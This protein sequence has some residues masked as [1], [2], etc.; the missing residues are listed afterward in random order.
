MTSP[1]I[2]ELVHEDLKEDVLIVTQEEEPLPPP[3]VDVLTSRGGSLASL[4]DGLEFLTLGAPCMI[5]EMHDEEETDTSTSTLVEVH[6]S[7]LPAVGGTIV[8]VG[9]TLVALQEDP[10]HQLIQDMH[11][12][13]SHIVSIPLIETYGDMPSG[14]LH[15]QGLEQHVDLA[16]HLITP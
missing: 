6:P 8:L 9:G 15:D 2:K 7:L 3:V 11:S 5:D 4:Q 14:V 1:I 13:S 10:M 12:L 16:Q